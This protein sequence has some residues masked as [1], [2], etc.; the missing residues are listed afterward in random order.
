MVAVVSQ[1]REFAIREVAKSV[2]ESGSLILQVLRTVDWAHCSD[3][4]K[5]WDIGFRES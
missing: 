1:C 3:E 4:R 2:G 5:F